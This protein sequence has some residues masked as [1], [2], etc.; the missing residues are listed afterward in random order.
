MVENEGI[1]M[2]ETGAG[3]HRPARRRTDPAA[4]A[5]G[6]DQL[7]PEDDPARQL[8]AVIARLHG[9]LDLARTARA[10]SSDLGGVAERAGHLAEA[11]AAAAAGAAELIDRIHAASVDGGNVAGFAGGVASLTDLLLLNTDIDTATRAAAATSGLLLPGTGVA[12]QAG[13]VPDLAQETARAVRAVS[14]Q[15]LTVTQ[16][17]VAAQRAIGTIAAALTELATAQADLVSGAVTQTAVL[18]QVVRWIQTMT[19][20]PDQERN[21]SVSADHIG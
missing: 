2:T 4:D 16:T 21:L 17:S 15:L 9:L 19:P 1:Q 11:T 12:A 6:P 8:A 13:A 20:A 18:D 3:D 7:A 10:G 14:A 5:R